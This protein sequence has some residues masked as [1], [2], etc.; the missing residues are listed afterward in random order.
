MLKITVLHIIGSAMAFKASRL[1][2]NPSP[3]LTRF[4]GLLIFLGLLSF[5]GLLRLPRHLGFLK[6]QGLLRFL[7]LVRS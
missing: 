6:F 2:R 7:G 3:R 5:L 4:L 1:R